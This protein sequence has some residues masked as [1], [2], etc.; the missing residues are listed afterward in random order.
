MRVRKIVE[1]KTSDREDRL[2]IE[3]RIIKPIQEMDAAWSG[4]GEATARG[5]RG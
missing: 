2:A 3:F 4:C 1:L 5:R